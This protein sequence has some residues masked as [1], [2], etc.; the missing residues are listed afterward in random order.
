MLAIELTRRLQDS[1]ECFNFDIKLKRGK[2]QQIIS[3]NCGWLAR[4][5]YC[6]SMSTWLK[7]GIHGCLGSPLNPPL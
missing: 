4:A 1:K 7:G 5:M 2:N 6:S 3:I